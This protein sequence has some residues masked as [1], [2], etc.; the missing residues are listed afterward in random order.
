MRGEKQSPTGGEPFGWCS[1]ERRVGG[2]GK[3]MVLCRV[4]ARLV[5]E[6]VPAEAVTQSGIQIVLYDV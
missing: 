5:G 1:E 2:G 4:L 6:N 3:A